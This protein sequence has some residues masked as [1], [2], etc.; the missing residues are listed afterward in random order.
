MTYLLVRLAMRTAFLVDVV[1]TS[2]R[3]FT[4]DRIVV[5]GAGIVFLARVAAVVYV[6]GL[7]VF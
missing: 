2:V 7:F 5:Y 4:T 6:V 3:A 1:G